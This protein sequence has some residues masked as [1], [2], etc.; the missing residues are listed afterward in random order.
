MEQWSSANNWQARIQ[1]YDAHLEAID[2]ADY[3]DKRLASRHTRQGIVKGLEGLLGR[4]MAEYQNE[5]NPQ[6]IAQIASAAKTIMGESR[7]EFN[8]LPTQRTQN[9]NVNIE[10]SWEEMF[11]RDDTSS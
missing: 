5:L 4:V 3:E 7:Q 2:L 10:T 8:D 6:T 1:S 9:E 11:K